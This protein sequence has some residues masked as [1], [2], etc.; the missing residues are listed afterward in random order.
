MIVSR[1]VSWGL[2]AAV[3]LVFAASCDSPVTSA[4]SSPKCGSPMHRQFDFWIGTW[5][6]TEKGKPAGENRIEAIDGGCVLLESWTGVGGLTGHSLNTYDAS[7]G[8][9]HQT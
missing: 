2:C 7:R 5:R 4:E 6:V 1:I 3:T 8:V 9:W